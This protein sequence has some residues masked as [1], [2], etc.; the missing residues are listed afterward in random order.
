M[1]GCGGDEQKREYAVPR[2]LC[3]TKIDSATLTP[4][5]PPGRKITVRNHSYTGIGVKGCQVVVD[6]NVVLSTTQAW[7][8]KGKTT[9]YFAAGQTLQDPDRSA[10]G[11]RFLYSG[12]QSFGKTQGCVDAKYQEELYTA[13]QA[14]GSKH[15]DAD[16]MKRV[17]VSYT[18]TVEK[19]AECTAGSGA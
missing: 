19:S 12:N 3:G 9:A 11:G 5:F 8:E 18:D 14:E 2:T 6:N 16:A 10:S 13:V 1:S 4:F 17:I 15:K 7:L